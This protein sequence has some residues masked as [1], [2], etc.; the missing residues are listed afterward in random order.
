MTRVKKL[1]VITHPLYHRAE[2]DISKREKEVLDAYVIEDLERIISSAAREPSTHVVFSWSTPDLLDLRM[3]LLAKQVP[4]TRKTE[5]SP[6]S[7]EPEDISFV[8][9]N[10]TT[11]ARLRRLKFAPKVTVETYG[12]YHEHC[13]PS[14]LGKALSV[15]KAAKAKVERI[16]LLGGVSVSGAMRKVYTGQPMKGWESKLFRK[17]FNASMAKFQRFLGDENMKKFEYA[18]PLEYSSRRRPG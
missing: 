9:D 10:Y 1:L 17:A 18:V 14:N 7:G 4:R 2:K 13:A 3:R 5:T 12:A 15:L 11:I 6:E 8:T 16:R